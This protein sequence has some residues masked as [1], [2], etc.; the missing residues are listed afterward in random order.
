MEY[1]YKHYLSNSPTDLNVDKQIYSICIESR[2]ANFLGND[3]QQSEYVEICSK[4]LQ[5]EIFN[6]FLLFVSVYI[7]LS[8]VYDAFYWIKLY[9]VRHM[10]DVFWWIK[11]DCACNVFLLSEGYGFL[12]DQTLLCLIP[13]LCFIGSNCI[14]FLHRS[15]YIVVMICNRSLTR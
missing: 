11:L 3:V 10:N 4:N 12:L 5:I 6:L 14:A 1:C 15:M 2:L 7:C 8:C 13:K 9:C